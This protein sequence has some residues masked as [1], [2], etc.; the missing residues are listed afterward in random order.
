MFL[1]NRFGK[2]YARPEAVPPHRRGTV[3][4]LP[5]QS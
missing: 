1:A 5:E 4:P 2:V 3:D